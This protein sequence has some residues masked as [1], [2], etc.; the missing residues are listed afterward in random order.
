RR[1]STSTSP[2][3]FANSTFVTVPTSTPPTR[4]GAPGL[5]PL[6]SF[7]VALSV[8]FRA[9]GEPP[10]DPMYRMVPARTNR[11][12]MTTTPTRSS[13]QVRAFLSAISPPAYQVRGGTHASPTDGRSRTP[14]ET[15]L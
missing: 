2:L 9:Q 4:T 13:V 3:P 11:L 10:P 15:P 5:S 7:M 8:Y 14:P 12:T 6:T 1:M